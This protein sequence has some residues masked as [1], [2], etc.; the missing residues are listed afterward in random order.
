M[1][2]VLALVLA[3]AVELLGEAVVLS[4]LA[5]GVTE[6][7]QCLRALIVVGAEQLRLV[8]VQLRR[9]VEACGAGVRG[10][11]GERGVDRGLRVEER[12]GGLALVGRPVAQCGTLSGK[13]IGFAGALGGY[14]GQRVGSLTA[15][16]AEV[17][18]RG[19]VVRLGVVGVGCL[20]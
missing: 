14:L 6:C 12:S 5:V 7:S 2:G 19:R 17:V 13:Q 10:E 4:H 15:S 16:V 8:G 3:G 20:Q 18:E 11:V 9:G 1:H